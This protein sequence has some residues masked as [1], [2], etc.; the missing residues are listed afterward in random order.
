MRE[1]I[2]PVIILMNRN[3]K[4]YILPIVFCTAALFVFDVNAD[5]AAG[6]PQADS[7]QSEAAGDIWQQQAELAAAK[8]KPIERPRN[9]TR[10]SWLPISRHCWNSRP[11]K[12]KRIRR[13]R[14]WRKQKM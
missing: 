7:V 5:A 13:S 3:K 9:N 2:C 1:C 6:V 8:R 14:T 4:R 12:R 11:V 10:R